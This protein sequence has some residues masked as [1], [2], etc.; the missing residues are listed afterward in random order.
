MASSNKKTEK[1][2]LK[3][4]KIIGTS[5]NTKSLPETDDYRK[6]ESDNKSLPETDNYRK[7][8]SEQTLIIKREEHGLRKN[9]SMTLKVISI[10]WLIFT[11]F[12]VIT[13]GIKD[14]FFIERLFDFS[15]PVLIAFITSSLATVVGL[16]AIALRYYFSPKK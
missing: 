15:D 3:N 12:I 13:S 10:S 8:E 11:A 5:Q 6:N 4:I 16:W 2:L 1:I 7:R 14:G 9:L